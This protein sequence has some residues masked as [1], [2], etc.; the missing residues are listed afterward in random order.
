MKNYEFEIAGLKRSLP[1]Y[2]INE[3]LS[4]AGFVIFGDSQLTENAAKELLKK[5]P[6]FDLI[7]TAEAKSIPLAHEMSRQAGYKKYIVARKSVKVYMSNPISVVVESI[8]T[9]KEQKLYLGTEDIEALKG[10]RVL[11]V[12][13]VI[14]TGESLKAM[15]EL[16]NLAGA[17]I[18]A[19]MAIL[20]EGAAKNRDDIIFLK[21]LPLFDGKG[22]AI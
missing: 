14:S 12:D 6:D 22:K 3:E 1:M 5:A 21:P 15:E 2:K 7:F 8:T 17:K 16:A 10:K 9:Q 18:V 19:R 13:D 20:A 4:I 11:L